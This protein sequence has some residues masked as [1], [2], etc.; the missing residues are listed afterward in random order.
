MIDNPRLQRLI[1]GLNEKRYPKGLGWKG[2]FSWLLSILIFMNIFSGVQHE[3]DILEPQLTAD[4]K[5]IHCVTSKSNIR[6]VVAMLPGIVKHIHSVRFLAI[7]Y[8]FKRIHGE[9]NEWE[10]ASM[11]DRYQ[12]RKFNIY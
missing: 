4:K 6:L 3:N 8:T 11:L 2:V 5:Y 7:D 10:V 12:T 1:K 9:F